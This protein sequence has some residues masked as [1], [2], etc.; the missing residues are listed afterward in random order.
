[1]DSFFQVTKKLLEPYYLILISGQIST[2]TPTTPSALN[3]SWGWKRENIGA[4][5]TKSVG[6]A[7][8][9]RRFCTKVVVCCANT[10]G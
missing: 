8:R 4:S 7:L 10:A 3:C 2:K 5:P 9:K 1:M 6:V